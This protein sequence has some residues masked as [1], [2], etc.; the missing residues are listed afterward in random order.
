M[1]LLAA[2]ILAMFKAS[3]LS[4]GAG[5]PFFLDT[6]PTTSGSD[7]DEELGIGTSTGSGAADGMMKT[8]KSTSGSGS[9]LNLIA[10]KVSLPRQMVH[11][12]MLPSSTASLAQG[13]H[14]ECPQRFIIT[15]WFSL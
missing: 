15:V 2:F 9:G 12:M 7:G 5:R 4:L 13:R 1:S 3:L 14:T 8:L 6:A 10:L 11:F